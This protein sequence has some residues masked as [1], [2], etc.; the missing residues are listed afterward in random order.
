MTDIPKAVERWVVLMNDH[1][2]AEVA[3]LL[4]IMEQELTEA[5]QVAAMWKATACIIGNEMTRHLEGNIQRQAATIEGLDGELEL[6]RTEIQLL[7]DA[8]DSL[9]QDVERLT[10]QFTGDPDQDPLEL[11]RAKCEQYWNERRISDEEVHS[12]LGWIHVQA[13]KAGIRLAA[14]VEQLDTACAQRDKLRERNED[15]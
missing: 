6:A 10:P 12:F 1:T 11:I 7:K 4:V 8:R 14:V 13:H 15:H 2:H 3:K 9:I 5:R